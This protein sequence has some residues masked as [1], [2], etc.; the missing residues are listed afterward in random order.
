MHA[1][2][3][4]DEYQ[5]LEG[6]SVLQS[7]CASLAKLVTEMQR[8]FLVQRPLQRRFHMVIKFQSLR[9]FILAPTTVDCKCSLGLTPGDI[10]RASDDVPR[11]DF[12]SQ[13]ESCRW[14][15]NRER[16]SGLTGDA[17]SGGSAPP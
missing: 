2:A 4:D 10:Q 13:R 11:C 5:L 9:G 7:N 1:N 14:D 12:Q 6:L 16:L 17:T 3:L 15:L 8:D